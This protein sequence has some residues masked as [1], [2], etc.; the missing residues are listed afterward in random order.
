M[1]DE[2]SDIFGTFVPEPSHEDPVRR[3]QIQMKRPLPKKFYENV[4]V[5]ADGDSFAVKLDGR[6]VK[7]PARN[8][9]LL[10]TTPLAELVAVEWRAQRDVIDPATMPVTRLANTAIDAVAE[11]VDMVAA[12]ILRFAGTDMIFY[13]AD[14]PQELVERQNLSWNPLLDWAA[15]T[16]G[17]RFILAVGVMHQ[18]QPEAAIAAFE[19]ALARHRDPFA[20]SALHVMTTLTGSALIGLALAEGRISLE[21]AWSLAHLDED[22]TD[23]HWGIDAEAAHRRAK[24]FEEMAAAYGVFSAR[25]G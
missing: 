5:E 15:E 19:K 8:T 20:L 21:E 4:S 12:E 2:L 25:R 1:R 22:W 16:L 10:P 9:L 3:A 18:E 17:A 13:R 14:T 24:R 6:P 7:T 23:E 11:Q